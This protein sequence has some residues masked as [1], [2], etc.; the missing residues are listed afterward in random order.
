[1][2]GFDIKQILTGNLPYNE[3]QL[4]YIPFELVN[5][6]SNNS[7]TIYYCYLIELKQKFTYD[8]TVEDIFLAT[9]VKLDPEIGCT[10]F[11][12]CFDRGS[13]SVNLRYRGTINLLPDQVSV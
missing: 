1:M 7:N 3:E 8:V 13:I 9:R 4:S 2:N 6:G 12:M 11:D 5:H 10:E